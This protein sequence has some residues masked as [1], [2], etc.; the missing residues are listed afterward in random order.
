MGG[1]AFA[2]AGGRS[3]A[4]LFLRKYKVPVKEVKVWRAPEGDFYGSAVPEKDA[5][6]HLAFRVHFDKNGKTNCFR[7][8]DRK[9]N[10][11]FAMK[12]VDAC[13]Y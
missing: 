5:D 3:Y 12:L 11:D 13:S 4:E 6:R 8:S 1:T 10:P 2:A 7:L 9:D